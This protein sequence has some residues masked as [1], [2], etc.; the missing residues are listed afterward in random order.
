LLEKYILKLVHNISFSLF[1]PWGRVVVVP[2][3]EMLPCSIG[4]KFL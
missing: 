3:N 2:L 1:W 4:E